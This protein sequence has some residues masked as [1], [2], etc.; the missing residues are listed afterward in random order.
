M[1]LPRDVQELINKK[2]G[3][4]LKNSFEAKVLS[5]F[6]KVKSEM[7]EEFLD[8]KVTQEIIAG[9]TAD[10]ISGTLGGY[11]NLFSYIGFNEGDE[12]RRL[13][14]GQVSMPYPNPPN[15]RNRLLSDIERLREPRAVDPHNLVS[16]FKACILDRTGETVV[17]A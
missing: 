17:C 4:F 2:S 15:L 12:P 9:P 10:N 5:S 16:Y 14:R 1:A 11:G 7:I 13:A 6:E 8:H 3:A